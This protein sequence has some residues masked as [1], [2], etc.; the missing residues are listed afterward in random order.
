M[1]SDNVAVG[2]EAP[3]FRLPSA[4]GLVYSLAAM[5]GCNVVLV[6]YRGHW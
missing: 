2:G 5:R 3:D 6:F 1:K 4:D